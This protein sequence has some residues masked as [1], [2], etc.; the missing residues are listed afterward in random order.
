M[1]FEEVILYSLIIVIIEIVRIYILSFELILELPQKY[2]CHLWRIININV[3][4]I[5]AYNKCIC[6]SNDHTTPCT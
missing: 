2:M 4:D 1:N 3:N 6:F 5:G